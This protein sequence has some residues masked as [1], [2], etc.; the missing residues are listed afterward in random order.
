[1]K[2]LAAVSII[3]VLYAAVVFPIIIC[4]VF[5]YKV[6]KYCFTNLMKL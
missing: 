2:G 3:L 5:L 6:L 4:A 1:M